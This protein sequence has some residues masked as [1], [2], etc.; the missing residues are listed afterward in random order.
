MYEDTQNERLVWWMSRLLAGAAAIII[1]FVGAGIYLGIRGHRI[2]SVPGALRCLRA[3]IALMK[4]SQWNSTAAPRSRAR[5][6]SLCCRTGLPQR[7][8]LR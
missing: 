3:R 5:R 7:P 4:Q 6:K 2:T 8:Q 1:A